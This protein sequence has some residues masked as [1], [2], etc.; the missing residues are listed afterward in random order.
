M[1]GMILARNL[2]FP[3]TLSIISSLILLVVAFVFPR[4]R[5]WLVILLFVGL[6]AV[7]LQ[8]APGTLT[9]LRQV[10]ASK[11]SI[12][13]T[14]VFDVRQRFSSSQFSYGVLT[15]SLA[16][17]PLKA[18]LIFNSESEL[19]IGTRYYCVADI[20]ELSSDPVL[21]M[22]PNKYEATAYQL[23]KVDILSSFNVPLMLSGLRM[24]MLQ[25][26]DAKLGSEAGWAK[27]L[28]LSDTETKTA[29]QDELRRSGTLHLIVV[30]GL[31]VYFIYLVLVNLLRV[32]FPRHIAE[33]LFLPVIIVFAGL[34]N[35]APSITRSII[36]IATYIL[37]RAL[38]RP[39]SGYQTLSIS[40]FIITL[41]QPLQLFSLGLQ[42]S[43][44]CVAVIIMGLP[45]WRT[46]IRDK[47]SITPFT[48]FLLRTHD[49]VMIS[50]LSSLA[51]APL[52]LYYFGQASLNGIVANLLGIPL[53]SVLIPLSALLVIV[54]Q[55]SFICR[56]LANSYWALIWL[57]RDWISRT[58]SLPFSINGM[59]FNG[60]RAVALALGIIWLLTVLQGKFRLALR[61][62]LPAGAIILALFILPG[63]GQRT[64]DV[65][66][67]A[68]GTADCSLIRLAN[69]KT[70]LI[71][72]G[73]IPGTYQTDQSADQQALASSS[74]AARKLLPW[75]NRNG[76][77]SLDYVIISHMHLDHCGGLAAL[78][79]HLHIRH[80]IIPATALHTSFWRELSSSPE[81]QP[82]QVYAIADTC[83]FTAPGLR[84]KF[85]SPLPGTNVE[86][87]NAG[88][89]VCRVD[90]AG[91]HLLFCGDITA[92][93]EEQLVS[94]VPSELAC[95][96]LKIP[97]HGSRSSSSLAFL[98]A[99]HAHEAWLTCSRKNRFG[100]PH[101]ETMSRF[102]TARIP[103]RSTENGTIHLLLP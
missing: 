45:K 27:A 19:R 1:G 69:G 11:H 59:Y 97:H 14:L 33:L 24:R 21:D 101:P 103:V 83:S 38:Q 48:R 79:S 37:A 92:E 31:H 74:W 50:V 34:N 12:R 4:L 86:D 2:A 75:L 99:T 82:G 26:L 94:A 95:D 35:W 23:G 84:L 43:F 7:R 36:M 49:A 93:T 98:Q 57:W 62:A 10:L 15:Q 25:S 28:L 47:S 42:L 55:G 29:F 78:A 89:L 100:F 65:H 5:P 72:T 96:Y 16:G 3:L 60:Y 56:M 8:I 66:V 67:F 87:D 68:A 13:Q 61:I 76:I 46:V 52:T 73:G 58:A 64:Q 30:S 81:F 70:V 53:S 54:P 40:M 22:F 90:A 6:G 44:A 41:W 77:R 85:L 91:K 20:R 71:D 88:S 17:K 102:S 80:L 63:R 9:P 51:V 18:N 32:F 39:I